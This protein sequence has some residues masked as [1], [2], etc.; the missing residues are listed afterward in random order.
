[1]KQV[2]KISSMSLFV[3]LTI[4]GCSSS[5]GSNND[6]PQSNIP[7]ATQ[8]VPTPAD[9]NSSATQP[10]ESSNTSEQ[11][12]LPT[13]S[14]T[15][16]P[17]QTPTESETKEPSLPSQIP[18]EKPTEAEE[19]KKVDP[20]K[21]ADTWRRQYVSVQSR[22]DVQ[23][24]EALG[25]DTLRVNDAPSTAYPNASNEV[26]NYDALSDGR[27]GHF[28]G[29]YKLENKSSNNLDTL[30]YNFI[31]QPY[32]TYGMIYNDISTSPEIMLVGKDHYN[33]PATLTGSANYQGQVIGSL[34]EN[35]KMVS[36]PKIDGTSDIV[37]KFDHEKATMSGVLNT[38]SVGKITLPETSSTGYFSNE[39]GNFS[40]YS[41]E[42][43]NVEK[44]GQTQGGYNAYVVGENA[45]EV[46]GAIDVSEVGSTKE[47]KA[48][49]GGQKQ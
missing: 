4:A 2:F 18:A 12:Q 16:N 23:A 15:N 28:S 24:E 5:G 48:V 37:V 34:S 41:S 1:M 36:A 29:S 9:P 42:T 7:P 22:G 17:T 8:N 25:I 40:F 49:F 33:Q 47:Y 21:Y 44:F 11:T 35:G 19:A 14:E 43:P 3:A 46:I 6:N 31:N 13:T 20:S 27:L 10:T 39:K 32:S 30:N 26:I 45:N 38:N